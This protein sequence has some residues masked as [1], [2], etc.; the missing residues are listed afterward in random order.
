LET[1]VRMG[2]TVTGEHGVG[3][4]KL[5]SMCVQFSPA[6]REAMFAVKR[7]FDPAGILN[8]GKVIPTLHR[9]AEYGRMHVKRGLLPFADLER[10]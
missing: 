10:F 7:A 6:E 3:V 2:G 4:E 1:S 9:C 5:N 8:P